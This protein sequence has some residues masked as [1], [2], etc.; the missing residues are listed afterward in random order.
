MHNVFAKDASERF[1]GWV[2]KFKGMKVTFN[3]FGEKDKRVQTVVVGN[4]PLDLNKM[5]KICACERDGDPSDMLCRMRD[6]ANA[7]NTHHTLH[8]VMR[9]YLAANSPVTPT[10]PENAD[11]LDAPQTLLTQ[12]TGVDYRFH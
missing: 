8:S 9:D 2:I 1:G 5:Y 6:V 7:N 3:A 10:P 12:V 4:A 11:I